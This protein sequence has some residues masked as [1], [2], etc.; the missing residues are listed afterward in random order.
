ME[1][2]LLDNRLKNTKYTPQ[3]TTSGSLGIDLRACIHKPLHL[4]SQQVELIPTG[5]S[6]NMLDLG[7][8]ILPRSGTGHKQGLILGNGTG[9]IDE[10]YQQQLFV[11]AWNR[12]TEGQPIIISPMDRIAQLCFVPKITP[13]LIVVQEFT[14]QSNRKGFGSTGVK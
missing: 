8:L 4:Y 14:T 13:D 2:K 6:V 1:I 11:S 7:A 10:D 9:L 3:Y 5:L 12:N